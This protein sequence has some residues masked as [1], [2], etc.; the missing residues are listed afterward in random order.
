MAAG[1]AHMASLVV[2]WTSQLHEDSDVHQDPS[3]PANVDESYFLRVSSAFEARHAEAWPRLSPGLNV[4]VGKQPE[5]LPVCSAS[6]REDTCIP[7]Q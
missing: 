4:L 6:A 3:L 7:A 1:F 2:Q 5:R